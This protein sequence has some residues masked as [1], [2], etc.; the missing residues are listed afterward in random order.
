MD[1]GVNYIRSEI[2][3][4]SP[5]LAESKSEPAESRD[6]KIPLV[7]DFDSTI[8]KTDLVV[9]SL[10][11]LLR[12]RPA[13]LFAVLVWLLNG[14]ERLHDEIGQRI[15]FDAGLM[16][17][18]PELLEYLRTQLASGRSL[19]L[20]TTLDAQLARKVANHLRIFASVMVTHDSCTNLSPAVKRERLVNAFGEKG[21]DYV[22]NG[23]R[24]LAVW[25]AARKA[26]LVNPSP[27]LLQMVSRVTEVQDVFEDP[28]A[29]VKNYL[30]ALR[31]IHWLKNCLVFVALFNAH[32][33]HDPVLLG[34]TLLAFV[35]LCLCTSSGYLV[36]DVLDLSADR[37]HPQKRH[38]P[39]ASGLLPFSYA[40][41]MVPALLVLSC[42]LSVLISP[43][44]LGALLLYFTLSL[45]YSLCL[46]RVVLLDVIVL[47]NLYT[48]RILSGAAVLGAW[49]SER[50][51]S[52]SM[53]LFLSLA[54]VKRY[55]E[56]VVMRSVDGDHPNGR[57]YLCSD[58]DLLAVMGTASGFMA[59]LVLAL[60][61]WDSAAQLHGRQA[62]VWFLCPLLLY[63]LAHIWLMAHR[64]RIREDPVVFALYDRISRNLLLLM[65]I[66]ALLAA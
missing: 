3:G 16:P 28:P 57:N 2:P 63:W 4:A 29:P 34:K 52:F 36:N 64:R 7:V 22:A 42:T 20:T 18:R 12:E 59:V 41:T 19:V 32:G 58:A 37:R 50:L 62:S 13:Y 56:L 66:N 49:P 65:L 5:A 17:Y 21:F 47:A 45:A 51:L 15:S 38:R 55:D 60:Y 24:D 48:L 61:I 9:E 30:S 27:R 31:P 8:I 10:M 39:F 33:F 54:L 11:I 53:F 1:S 40:I 25:C 43:L 14:R 26:V 44:F 23:S 35:A 46:K 6:L